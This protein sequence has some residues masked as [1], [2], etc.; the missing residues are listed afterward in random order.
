MT[1]I[2]QVLAANMKYY[3]KAAKLSQERLAERSE[4]STT[5]IGMLEMGIRFP[6]AEVLER[7]ASALGVDTPHLFSLDQQNSVSTD[8]IS[9]LQLKRELKKA[10]DSAV[11]ETLDTLLCQA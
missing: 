3:R 9:A 10:L 7:L 4:L 8:K 6:S 2:R 1:D 5:Y 11:N